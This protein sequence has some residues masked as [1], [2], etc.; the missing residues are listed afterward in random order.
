MESGETGKVVLCEACRDSWDLCDECRARIVAAHDARARY[1][2]R[3]VV[4]VAYCDDDE[5]DQR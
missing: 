4:A 1:D 3:G 2:R 5:S